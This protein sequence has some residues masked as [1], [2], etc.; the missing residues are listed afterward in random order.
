MVF[1]GNQYQGDEIGHGEYKFSFHVPAKAGK[2]VVDV[3]ANGQRLNGSPFLMNVGHDRST[4]TASGTG[5]SAGL[6]GETARFTVDAAGRDVEAFLILPNGKRRAV[7]VDSDGEASYLPSMGGRYK[8][9]VLAAG[10][11]VEG[12]P[13]IVEVTAGNAEPLACDVHGDAVDAFVPLDGILAPGTMTSLEVQVRD[14]NGNECSACVQVDVGEEGKAARISDQGSGLYLAEFS[15]PAHGADVSMVPVNVMV[16]GSHVGGSPFAM[17]VVDRFKNACSILDKRVRNGKVSYLVQ[18]KNIPSAQDSWERAEDCPLSLIHQFDDNKGADA[19]P[20]IMTLAQ[21]HKTKGRGMEKLRMTGNGQMLQNKEV[22]VVGDGLSRGIVG[23]AARFSIFLP[24]QDLEAH[25]NV[26]TPWGQQLKACVVDT[27]AL[28]RALFYTPTQAGSH[29][30]EV[31][32]EGKPHSSSP[33]KVL[34]VGGDVDP[35]K[36]DV[37]G[38]AVDA[39]VPFEETLEPGTETS[40]GLQLR[41]THG[42]QTNGVVKVVVNDG[43]SKVELEDRGA[44]L[45]HARFYVPETSPAIVIVTVDGVHVGGSPFSMNVSKDSAGSTPGANGDTRHARRIHAHHACHARYAHHATPRHTTPNHATCVHARTDL[46]RQVHAR[47][48]TRAHTRAR[49]RTHAH[50]RTHARTHGRTICTHVVHACHARM[51]TQR[52]PMACA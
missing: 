16:N 47:T 27:S 36:C 21:Q 8:V 43:E 1:Q 11:H 25:V 46:P 15:A 31:I 39:F 13:F 26:T 24:S 29:L 48:H 52:A 22:E 37:H 30:V 45:H 6:A 20:N 49:M 23:E 40:L 10:Q 12:S 44:G 38:D 9:E 51:A 42:N 19:S 3:K 2:F 33:F 7:A 28:V 4:A 50:A 32:V 17:N 5:L 34:V 14:S 35:A 41:D 18:W